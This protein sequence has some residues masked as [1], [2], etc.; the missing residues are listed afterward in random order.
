MKKIL[1][2]VIMLGASSKVIAQDP[3]ASTSNNNMMVAGLMIIVAIILAFVIW[4]MGNVLITLGKEVL[5]KQKSTTQALLIG[6]LLL[7]S[8]MAQAQDTA[9]VQSVDN[10]GG[11]SSTLFWTLVMVLTIEVIAILFLMFM[12]KRMQQELNPETATARTNT[13]KEWWHNIDQKFF[14]KAV[15][16]EKEQDIM[17]DHDYDGIRELDNNLPPWWKYGFI[18]TII[19]SIIYLFY[20]HVGNGKSPEQE[21][22]YEIEIAELE[23][24]KYNATSADKIDEN[25]LVMSDESGINNGRK[26]FNMACFACHGDKGQGGAGPN[27]TDDYWIHK[28]GLVDIYNSIKFGYPDKGMQ[29]WEKVYSPKEILDLASYIKTLKGTNP[30]G[31]KAPEGNLWAEEEPSVEQQNDSTSVTSL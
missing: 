22:A 30:P 8:N 31:A 14:T 24:A 21:Y 1:T 12:I 17:L 19:C 18:V 4:A 16:I 26:I 11:L 27:L 13:L 5:K 10:Y 15:A 29:S 9:P 25:N 6:G 20:F 3:N 7:I 23:L 28:G 2:A